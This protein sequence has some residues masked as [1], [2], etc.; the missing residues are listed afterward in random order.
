MKE[1]KKRIVVISS[2]E[3]GKFF[4]MLEEAKKANKKRVH[5]AVNKKNES[6]GA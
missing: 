3:A 1:E 5:E 6:K 4:D 2:A